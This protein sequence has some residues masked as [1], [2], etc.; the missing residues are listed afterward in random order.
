M[1]MGFPLF[2]LGACLV[3]GLATV[4]STCA[5]G[6]G[7]SAPMLF[8]LNGLFDFLELAVVVCGLESVT[9]AV[10]GAFT[11]H[12]AIRYGAVVRVAAIEKWCGKC[13][14]SCGCSS[15]VV[16]FYLGW[17]FSSFFKR[18]RL[19]QEEEDNDEAHSEHHDEA[20]KEYHEENNAD[21]PLSGAPTV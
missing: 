6:N 9:K 4:L 14:A 5:L 18:K 20:P 19:P 3:A 13:P 17:K 7:Y 15:R 21:T 8:V 10:M 16:S 1:M 11:T 2:V 12:T